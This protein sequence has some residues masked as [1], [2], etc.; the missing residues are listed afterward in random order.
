[1][2]SPEFHGVGVVGVQLKGSGRRAT[3]TLESGCYPEENVPGMRLSSRC[4]G[5]QK[6]VLVDLYGLERG[7]CQGP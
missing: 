2:K 1:M 5:C 7:G 4:S 3:R 6:T